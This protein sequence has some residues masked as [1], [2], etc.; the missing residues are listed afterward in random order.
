MRN[1]YALIIDGMYIMAHFRRPYRKPV[2]K[3]ADILYMRVSSNASTLIAS[4]ILTNTHTAGIGACLVFLQR[5][6]RSVTTAKL[7]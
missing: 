4:N 6:F 2:R 1:D 5:H 3:R 7:K